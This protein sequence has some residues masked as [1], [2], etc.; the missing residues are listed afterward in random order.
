MGTG[1]RGLITAAVAVVCA[2]TVL[3]APGTA[4][5]SVAAPEPPPTPAATPSTAPGKDLEAVRKRLETLYHDAAVATD[6]YNA[7]EE[8]ARKQSAE[9]AELAQQ[10]AKV[11]SRLDDL[12]ERAGAAAAAQY[13]GG[14]LPPEAHLMLSENPTQFLDGTGRILQGQRAT[15][16]LIRETARTKEDLEQ[17]ERDATTQ[18]KKLEANRKAKASAQ[19]RIEKQIAAAEK[20]ESALEKEEIARLAELE[21]AAALK[22]QN[23][24]LDSGVLDRIR[25]EASAQ[26]RKAV[27]FATEQ[28]GLPYEWGAEGP[29]SYDCSGLTSRAWAKA[30]TPIPRTSQ[31]QW[32]R[33]KRIDIED[34]RPGDLVIYNKDASHVG[35]YVGAGS[36]VHAPRP[37]RTVTIAG[38]GS[39]PILGVVRPDAH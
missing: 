30:G 33:L 3:A 27:E 31:E 28:I 22:A 26:G 36:I 23:A 5:A 35:M 34:M 10:I 9:L 25:G 2:V 1:K 18:W 15:K 37:G 14:G 21:R 12:T 4:F 13:R 39:M 8:K 20:L 32:R 38:A 24:W 11:R 17:Y 7:A 16:G 29:G 6:A 19:K